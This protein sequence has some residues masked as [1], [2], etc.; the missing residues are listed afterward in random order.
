VERG[1]LPAID[2]DGPEFVYGRSSIAEPAGSLREL[3]DAKLAG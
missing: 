2:L 1:E 3:F